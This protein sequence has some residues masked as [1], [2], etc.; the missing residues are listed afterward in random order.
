[1]QTLVLQSYRPEGAPAWLHRC[2]D[3]AAAW[4]R[5]AGHGYEFVGDSLFELLP[6]WLRERCGGQLLP[7]TDLARLLLMRE[8]LRGGAARVIWLD[9][10][11]F[12]FAPRR[13]RIAS[14]DG[15]CFCD[16]V[17]LH[18]RP[19]GTAV[20]VRKVNNAAMLMD[21]ANPLLDFYIHACLA[22]G[23]RRARG[24]IGKLDFGTNLLTQLAHVL[25]LPVIRCV[26]TVNP[27]LGRDIGRGGGDLCATYAQ[28]C[29]HVMA[30]ANMCASLVGGTSAD[31]AGFDE[32]DVTRALDRLEETQ[33]DVINRHLA[34]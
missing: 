24:A 14:A 8:R 25:P 12:V 33:G 20:T 19:D 26:G 18:R 28:A 27:L 21:A 5:Q 2:M 3:S 10:D 16:E 31:G 1:M 34:A 17:W 9:A 15:Y 32:A 11:I 29:G 22:I 6:D 4:A 7:Q 13:L 30:A 23:A